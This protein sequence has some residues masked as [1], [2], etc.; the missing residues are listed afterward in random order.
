MRRSFFGGS[1]G[2]SRDAAWWKWR[3]RC[4]AH[5]CQA[6]ADLSRIT[7]GPVA[8]STRG[9]T[10]CVVTV[11]WFVGEAAGGGAD[12]DGGHVGSGSGFVGN[13]ETAGECGPV[14]GA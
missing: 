3:R 14:A 1:V 8:V 10:L 13:T 4:W 6:R 7:T 9:G 11:R 5:R 2:T 12:V